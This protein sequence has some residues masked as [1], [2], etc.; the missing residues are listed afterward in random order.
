MGKE[1]GPASKD[2]S[3]HIVFSLKCSL[4]KA[5]SFIMAELIRVT[6]LLI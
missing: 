2:D 3:E 4:E 1:E 6:N 5:L